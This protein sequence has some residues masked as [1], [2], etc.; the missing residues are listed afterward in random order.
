M[1]KS[2]VRSSLSTS[3]SRSSGLKGMSSTLRMKFTPIGH[4][5]PNG[6]VNPCQMEEVLH[7][8]LRRL[9]TLY[10]EVDLGDDFVPGLLVTDRNHVTGHED[11][12]RNIAANAA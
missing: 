6:R 5:F 11:S 4:P 9:G 8:R 7:E 1:S 10:H 12:Q 3:F 2:R